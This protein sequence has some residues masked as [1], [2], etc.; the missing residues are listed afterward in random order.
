MTEA[1]LFDVMGEKSTIE[2]RIM[3]NTD[4]V[5]SIAFHIHCRLPKTVLMNDLIQEGTIGLIEAAKNFKNDKNSSFKTYASIR[6]RGSILDHLRKGS[7][8]PRS[9]HTNAKRITKA[10]EAIESETSDEAKSQQIAE[11]MG[12]TLEDYH[13]MLND[14]VVCNLISLEDFDDN[15][16]FF[17]GDDSSNNPSN[18]VEETEVRDVVAKLIQQLPQKE[19]LVLS[20]YVNEELTFKEIA[21]VLELTESRACQIYSQAIKRLQARML[22]SQRQV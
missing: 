13:N 14:T 1:C 11:K 21:Y 6:I 5:K 18:I 22:T 3:S 12:I 10:I 19:Q 20:L 17:V 15:N 2:T 4:L 8:V 16:E 9:V 7:W